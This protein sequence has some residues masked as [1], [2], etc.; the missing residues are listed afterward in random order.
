MHC[1]YVALERRRCKGFGEKL[2]RTRAFGQNEPLLRADPR[3]KAVLPECE[4]SENRLLQESLKTAC[5]PVNSS[6]VRRSLVLTWVVV[7]S[8]GP[9][10]PIWQ[11]AEAPTSPRDLRPDSDLPQSLFVT[12]WRR[13]STPVA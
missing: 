9:E 6:N 2:W 11:A 8:A 3:D 1:S 7:G 12:R 13:K 4:H 5:W 10:A